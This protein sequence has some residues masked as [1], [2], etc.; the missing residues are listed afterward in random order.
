M[1]DTFQLHV[2]PRICGFDFDASSQ[3]FPASRCQGCS[4]SFAANQDGTRDFGDVQCGHH[5]MFY[6]EQKL[7]WDSLPAGFQFKCDHSDNF[8]L[9]LRKTEGRDWSERIWQGDGW[10]YNMECKSSLLEFW[11]GGWSSFNHEGKD[12]VLWMTQH[13]T[14]E[15][16]V[17]AHLTTP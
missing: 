12:V 11:E 1:F 8:H 7:R 16:Y 14:V 15:F 4:Y 13:G 9:G 5:T 17:E 10:K 3:C 6:S 2:A